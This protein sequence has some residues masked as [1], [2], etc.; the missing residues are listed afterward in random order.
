MAEFGTAVGHI[1]NMLGDQIYESLAH[2]GETMTIAEIV[3]YAYDQID[4]ARAELK[5]VAK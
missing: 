3:A 2:A 5:A 4:Q 1:R